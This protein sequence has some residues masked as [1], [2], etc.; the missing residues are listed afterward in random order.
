MD[1]ADDND[2][3]DAN[4]LCELQ[5]LLKLTGQ[6]STGGSAK[7]LIQSGKCQLNGVVETRRAK[8]LFAGDVVTFGGVEYSVDVLVSETN[9][10]YKPKIKKVK[11]DAKIDEFGN[12][13]FGGRFRSE[14]WRAE[15]KE[16]KKAK[17]YKDGEWKPREARAGSAGESE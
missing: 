6:I 15:R 9:Y 11:P 5:T 7:V 10:V 12:K 2:D 1:N 16:K 13:E 14:E 8:K 4:I 3:S 17:K